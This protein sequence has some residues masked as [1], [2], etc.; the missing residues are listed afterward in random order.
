MNLE[1]LET[2]A[3]GDEVV[4]PLFP[5]WSAD[6]YYPGEGRADNVIGASNLGKC[7]RAMAYRMAKVKVTDPM[8]ESGHHSTG[9]GSA[10][11]L[12]IQA[13]AKEELG[14]MVE[15]V[16]GNWRL[17]IPVKGSETPIVVDSWSD[18]DLNSPPGFD[19][20]E[21]VDIKSMAPFGFKMKVTKEGPD[22]GHILQIVLAM[23]ALRAEHGIPA[24][25]IRGRLVMIST[26]ELK[27][28][29]RVETAPGAHDFR[30]NR[31]REILIYDRD[32]VA[33]MADYEIARL[34]RIRQR[35][36]A[37]LDV[38]RTIPG[39]TPKGAT[40]VDPGR[41]VWQLYAVDNE[42]EP[43][44]SAQPVLIDSGSTW[45]CRYCGWVTRCAEDLNNG[46]PVALSG[47]LTGGVVQ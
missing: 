2:V 42:P 3:T 15:S 1:G 10:I 35:L 9:L 5:K 20:I 44:V 16:E 13:K 22:R 12:A 40:I 37:G 19:G 33:A 25:K 14:R 46:T 26:A 39:V 29:D 36:D 7:S 28:R 6:R 34:A 47:P 24:D 38:P 41:G 18:L 4:A 32:G 31:Y 21:V 43:G 11:H 23:R 45:H 8:T 30:A 17:T 27:G